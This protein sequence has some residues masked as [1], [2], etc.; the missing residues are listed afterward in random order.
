MFNKDYFTSLFGNKTPDFESVKESFSYILIAY[1]R[2]VIEEVSENPSVELAGLFS[3]IGGNMG[4]FI[5][6]SVLTFT[7]IFELVFLFVAIWW[8][9]RKLGKVHSSEIQTRLGDSF[10]LDKSV[11]LTRITFI[12]N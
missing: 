8:A 2:I 6:P 1:D 4:L 5:G 3:N 9:Q 10:Q 12:E 7:E 11:K